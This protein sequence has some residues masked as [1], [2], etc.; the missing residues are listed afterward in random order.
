MRVSEREEGK[1]EIFTYY[2]PVKGRKKEGKKSASKQE[3]T[4]SL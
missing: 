3:H 4:H 1:R 2:E